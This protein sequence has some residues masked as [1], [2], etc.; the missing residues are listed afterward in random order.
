[1][2]ILY[3][4]PA[5]MVGGAER[6]GVVQI[7]GLRELGLEVIPVIGGPEVEWLRGQLEGAGVS[8][9]VVLQEFPHVSTRRLSP[10][11]RLLETVG[12]LKALIFARKAVEKLARDRQVDAVIANCVHGWVTTGKIFRRQQMPLMWRAGTRL[13]TRAQ[14]VGIGLVASVLK[15]SAVLPNC[16]ALAREI[17]PLVECP[18]HLVPNGIDSRRFDPATAVPRFRRGLGL[19]GRPVVGI[20]TRPQPE[21]GMDL[22]AEVI[23][24]AAARIPEVHVLI[25]GDGYRRS[26]FEARFRERGLLSHATF[27]GHVDDIESF[28]ASCDVVI[29]TSRSKSAEASSNALLE[30][31]AMERPVVAT[32]VCGMPEMIENGREGWLLGEGDAA[33]FAERL[34]ELCADEDLRRRMGRAG[35]QRVLSRYGE[36]QSVRKL[37]DLL[38]A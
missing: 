2:R 5:D 21:K 19:E 7:R 27:I 4:Q 24:K 17:G 38:G 23:E 10:R 37:A 34:R 3:V 28:Y 9:Y 14:R 18:T 16:E 30:A 15:P 8:D 11:A 1:M 13:G 22:L 31:M 32:D 29:L 36:K 25:A 26:E 12:N 6:Q 20:V 35:R 33:A